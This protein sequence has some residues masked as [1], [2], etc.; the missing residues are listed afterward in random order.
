MRMLYTDYNQGRSLSFSE[1][2]LN[3]S[4]TL[5]LKVTAGLDPIMLP[6]EFGNLPIRNYS[7]CV[8]FESFH[9]IL[10]VAEHA[11]EKQWRL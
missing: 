11:S 1:N 10:L 7:S 4:T 5:R 8:L 6:N 9:F 2:F 3:L